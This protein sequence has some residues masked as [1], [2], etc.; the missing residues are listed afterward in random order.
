MWRLDERQR[1]C[2]IYRYYLEKKEAFPL[3]DKDTVPDLGI[4]RRQ[5]NKWEAG[6]VSLPN[7]LKK[8]SKS[9][10]KADL[11]IA[12]MFRDDYGVMEMGKEL[13]LTR[14]ECRKAIDELAGRLSPT[15]P[16]FSVT[17]ERS[18]RLIRT[19]Q[20]QYI[21]YRWERTEHH[22]AQHDRDTSIMCMTLSVRFAL[23]GNKRLSRDLHRLRCKLNIPSYRLN[24]DLY[25]YDGY[26]S[27]VDSGGVYYWMFEDR[28]VLEGD[29]VFM[30][31]NALEQG[32]NGDFATRYHGFQKPGPAVETGNMAHSSGKSTAASAY[33][34]T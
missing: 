2:A 11:K 12:E 21:V 14:A 24:F 1:K 23:S 28:K 3:A 7:T 5:F 25:E 30:M 10:D 4:T 32:P 33:R 18:K 15:F 29:L 31:T 22:S 26:L 19:F 8:R 13:G 17:P 9:W 34:R 27:D 6:E 16:K 20:G